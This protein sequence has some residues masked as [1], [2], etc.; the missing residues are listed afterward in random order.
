MDAAA[1]GWADRLAGPFDVGGAGASQ[2][3]DDGFGDD[4]GDAPDGFEVAVGSDGETGLDHVDPHLL[5]YLGEFPSF[6]S[7]TSRHGRLF[8]AVAHGGGCRR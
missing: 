3:A 7:A 4:L 5:K 2:A 6:S 1:F 8:L